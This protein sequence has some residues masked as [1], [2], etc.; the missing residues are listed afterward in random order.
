MGIARNL[1]GLILILLLGSPNL[2]KAQWKQLSNGM[3]G[4]NLIF[5]IATI[6]DKIYVASTGGLYVSS[7]NGLTWASVN[8]NFVGY[9]VVSMVIVGTTIFISVPG[10]GTYRSVDGGANWTSINYPNGILGSKLVAIGNTVYTL[11]GDQSLCSISLSSVNATKVAT[12]TNPISLASSATKLFLGTSKDGLLQSADGGVSWTSVNLGIAAT[13]IQ[14]VSADGQVMLVSTGQALFLSKDNGVIWSPINV[15]S[16]ISTLMVAGNLTFIGNNNGAYRSIDGGLT[17]TKIPSLPYT[18]SFAASGGN[19][20]A[21]ARFGFFRSLD[22][23]DSWS[24][25]N[26][27]MTDRLVRKIVSS[28]NTL[29]AATENALY[30]SS[31]Q[32]MSWE[33]SPLPL[34]ADSFIGPLFAKGQIVLVSTYQS[35]SEVY[36]S[37]NSGISWKKINSID[38]YYGFATIGNDLYLSNQKGIFVS[39]DDGTSWSQIYFASGTVGE[40]ISMGSFL[41]VSSSEGILRITTSGAATSAQGNLPLSVTAGIISLTSIDNRVF[42]G[43]NNGSIYTTTNDGNSWS[44]V[45]SGQSQFSFLSTMAVYDKQ[46]FISGI[47]FRPPAGFTSE[48]YY[49]F[50]YGSS[51]T[52]YSGGFPPGLNTV[53]NPKLSIAFLGD[54]MFAGTSS[55]GVWSNCI[56]LPKPTI[57]GTNLNTPAPLLT[58]SSNN[59]NQWYLNGVAISNATGGTWT[60]TQ[61]GSYFVKVTSVSGCESM[62]SESLVIKCIVPPQPTISVSGLNTQTPLLTSSSVEGN[63]W[64]FNG[65]PI[66]NAT[67]NTL[68][69][70]QA[71][72]YSVTV[73]NTSDC[74]SIRSVEQAVVVTGDIMSPSSQDNIVTYPNP[75]VKSIFIDFSLMPNSSPLQVEIF[76]ASNRSLEKFERSYVKTIEVDVSRYPSGLYFIHFKNGIQTHVKKFIK[77]P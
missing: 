44:L 51:W 64:Y 22:L 14:S 77:L 41:L 23:G 26:A 15:P 66:V 59:G 74:Q 39:K 25:S 71:G 3:P 18:Q 73:S 28:G 6:S 43:F 29:I 37:S 21:G 53:Q 56:P 57:T 68:T 9:S 50:D 33:E 69:P 63:Q 42:A 34:R 65:T 30:R 5:S 55:S 13:N 40:M 35:Q 46:L 75:T 45:G 52:A 60:P 67:G 16:G 72:S 70:T 10:A 2:A 24:M 32:G 49:S 36:L 54:K 38:H 61:A 8:S 4:G 12:V 1:I 17:F 62:P 27:G 19:L 58:S 76:D 20:Y 7:N 47:A 11:A 48:I 31:N